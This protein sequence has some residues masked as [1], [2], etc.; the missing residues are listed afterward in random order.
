MAN[1][2]TRA[3]LNAMTDRENQEWALSMIAN[4]NL[5]DDYF[6]DLA[7]RQLERLTGKV[8]EDDHD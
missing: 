1:N 8:I 4:S 5:P 6:T 3:R 7:R 2:R